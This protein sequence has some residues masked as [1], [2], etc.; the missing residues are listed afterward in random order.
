MH[1]CPADA[2][3][4]D[5]LG[6]ITPRVRLMMRGI[7][8]VCCLLATASIA[9]LCA[10]EARGGA[11]PAIDDH[12]LHAA[13]NTLRH[14][15]N[16]FET[17]KM[18]DASSRFNLGDASG[19]CVIL[20]RSGRVMGV[21]SDATGDDLMLRRAAGHAMN[22]VMSDPA[23]SSLSARLR[24]E[25]AENPDAA[26]AL[27]SIHADLGRSL[28]I[29]LEVAGK[30]EPLIGRE[31]DQLARKIEPGVVGVA[32]RH[33][34]SLELA[35]PAHLRALNS[36]G[37]PAKL[38]LSIALR[39]GV[40]LKDISDLPNQQAL[41][42][43]S[44]R[45]AALWQASSEQPPIAT[46]RGDV[47]VPQS[48]VSRAGIARLADGIAQ[49]LLASMWPD[50]PRAPNEA[51]PEPANAMSSREPLGIMGD[52]SPTADQYRPLLASPLDQAL[53]AFALHRYVV[54]QPPG[55]DSA[56]V[57]RSISAAASL[58]RDLA[59]ITPAEDDPRND[60]AACAV[61]VHAVC[62]QTGV[63]NDPAIEQLFRDAA[64]R[65]ND[66]FDP[67]S[68]F[69][70]RTPDGAA[71][72]VAAH[73]QAMIAGALCRMID[74]PDRPVECDAQRVRSALDAAWQSVPDPQHI[75][76]LPWIGWAE[77]DY[78]RF[79]HQPLARVRELQVMLSA[80]EQVRVAAPEDAADIA[81]AQLAG[82]FAL[83][84]EATGL[85]SASPVVT[86][87]STRPSAW[88]PSAVRTRELV[89][90]DKADAAWQAHLTTMRFLM[91]LS[92]RPELA[93]LY[94]NPPRALGG[95]RTALWDSDQAV[96]AQ[97]MALIAAAET[98]KTPVEQQ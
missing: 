72:G 36:G 42:L 2:P 88:V 18:D 13:F 95:L 45:T 47:L 77:A 21:G 57:G 94:R 60:L 84:S 89:P 75:A 63:R 90:H 26:L 48:A 31:L 22:D 80:L 51:G 79:T 52:Y 61:I 74:V 65:I 8:M 50:P 1:E 58:L 44:F 32:L 76:L 66:S 24:R 43:Y 20:R 28:A 25:Q 62:E 82:G 33:N 37:E 17:P 73:T 59:G 4:A 12:Q 49:H 30:L 11:Q 91:Q 71:R 70:D 10:S 64:Q 93:G 14:W 7:T 54:A 67:G 87:Q 98:L 19:V 78:A 40:P 92:V 5:F 34:Q 46:T 85:G 81:R 83:I 3:T 27:D 86:A 29:E 69:I 68:G 41:G 39:A 23:L 16:D 55:T 35:F 97:A 9:M 56:V 96:P 38:L 53:A 15:V 6:R